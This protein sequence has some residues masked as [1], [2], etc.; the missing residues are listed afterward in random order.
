[1][2]LDLQSLIAAATLGGVVVTPIVTEALKS[3]YIPVPAQKHPRLTSIIVSL[4]VSGG[5]IYQHFGQ[6]LPAGSWA[7][8]AALTVLT[9]AATYNNLYKGTTPIK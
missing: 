6:T 4:L 2:L 5:Y 3:R 7:T 1:M 8:L 9:A